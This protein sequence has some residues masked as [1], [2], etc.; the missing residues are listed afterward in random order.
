[1]NIPVAQFCFL[2]MIV[3]IKRTGGMADN[4]AE[5]EKVRGNPGLS[6]NVRR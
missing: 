5:P 3:Q 6:Y 1:M 4:G 2:A